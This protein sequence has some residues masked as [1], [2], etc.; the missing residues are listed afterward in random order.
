MN[1]SD[2]HT[3]H[4]ILTLAM[5]ASS[6]E[7]FN[8][9]RRAHFPRHRNYLDA[10]LTLFHRLP[11]S[12]EVRTAILHFT[13]STAFELEAEAVWNMGNGVAIG[14]RSAALISLH[15][16]MQQTLDPWLIPYDRRVLWPHITIQNNVSVFKAQ[17]LYDSLQ[18]DFQPF[19][20]KATGFYTW[21]HKKG[22]IKPAA[23]Y[24]FQA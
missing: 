2:R 12:D 14:I 15:A 19:S 4:L 7:R 9:L 10:H 6:Q 21:H 8:R 11:A 1:V 16:A 23:Y 18:Q 20:F 17:Q 3:A 24:A 22:P 5:E 13:R